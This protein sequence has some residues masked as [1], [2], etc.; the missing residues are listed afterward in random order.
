MQIKL[1]RIN[2]AVVFLLV[3]LL[4]PLPRASNAAEAERAGRKEAPPSGGGCL[5]CHEGIEVINSRMAEAWGADR[6]CEVCHH[7][8]P[9]AATKL[10]AHD[11]LIANPGDLRVI[12]GTCG[13]C[14]SDYGE[15]AKV[16][17]QG[18]GDHVGRVM[19]SLM[20]TAA[21]E[22]AGTRYLWGEQENRSATYGVRAVAG[23]GREGAT[24]GAVEWLRQLPPASHSN[25]DSLLRGACLRCHLWTEDKTTPGVFRPAGCSA[26]H[27]LYASDGLSRSGDPMI[28]KKE[29]G[30]PKTHSITTKIPDSQCLLCHNDG[31]ARI[32][33]SY[34]GLA[35]TNPSLGAEAGSPGGEAGYGTTLMHVRPDVHYRRGMACID[36]HD[37]VDLHGD[38]NIYS[39][40]EEQ[41]GIRCESCHGSPSEPPSFQT[42]RGRRLDNIEISEQAPYLRTKIHG[43]RLPIPVLFG[44]ESSG[45]GPAEIW[46]EGHGRLECYACH[47]ERQQQ[48]YACHMIRDD[49]EPSPIDW[50]LGI[51][52]REGP[53]PSA[54]S[55]TGRKLLQQ[56]D[57]PAL[58]FNRKGRISPF[59]PGGQAIVTH[60]DEEG[61]TLVENQAFTTAG[62]LYGFSMNP[63]QPHSVGL[64]SRSCPSCH[65]S[66][67]ALG[68]GS[69]LTDL[70]RLGLPLNFSPDRIVDED[71]VRIQDS[72]HEGVRP[73][74]REELVGL[75]R[76]GACVVCHERAP[77]IS[78][79]GAAGSDAF[80]SVK[81][82]DGRHHESMRDAVG[83]EQ[84]HN[85]AGTEE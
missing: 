12:E 47:T 24:D 83:Q 78:D 68:L 56:W 36:C 67:K 61:E 11:G 59:A 15:M 77:E 38:G 29:T 40:Q 58:G 37:S 60:I 43:E 9:S 71:G 46:H 13:K 49:R 57:A 80:Q 85:S 16:E 76:T 44:D 64:A 81:G 42:E 55:W 14:H 39:H 1:N 3:A 20:A 25:A 2:G 28:D 17:S 32:G 53:E 7:G 30:H 84:E 48:C 75:L 70:K 27:V 19:R 63:V 33:L 50:G 79:R 22:I 52:E 34:V 82:S 73:F 45:R 35:V 66:T 62:G 51:G 41:V 72:A 54:G 23:H 65:S 74:N 10:E 31:G 26:C 69:E 18:I 21:G 6:K 4:L 5:S 8:R